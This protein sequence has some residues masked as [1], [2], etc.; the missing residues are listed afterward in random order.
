MSAK[1]IYDRRTAIDAIHAAALAYARCCADQE[2]HRRSYDALPTP[3][4]RYAWTVRWRELCRDTAIK[5]Q[6]VL[7]EAKRLEDRPTGPEI[8]K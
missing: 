6:A 2:G 4:L 1:T 8:V 3:E 7:A 5:A